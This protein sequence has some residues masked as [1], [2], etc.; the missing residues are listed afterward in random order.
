MRSIIK[1]IMKNSIPLLALLLVAACGDDKAGQ[2]EVQ[3]MQAMPLPVVEI[4]TKTVTTYSDYPTSIEG[5]INSEVRAKIPGYITEV[6]VDEGQ[7]VRRGQTLFRLETESL[8]Q[9][10]EA[11]KANVNAAQVE[12]D[13]LTPLVEKDII[14]SVQLETA[15]ARLQQSKS[16][17]N[18]VV[19]SIG[20][21]TITSPV[22]G[23]VGEIRLRMG[24]LISPNDQDPLTTVSDISAVYA[25]FSMNEKEYLDFIQNTAGTTKA[26]KINNLPEV[27]L[28]LANGSEYPQKGTIETINSQINKNTGAVSFRALFNNDNGILNNGNSGI[29]KVPKIYEDVV[30]V[31][32]EA[33]FENQNN[34]FVYTLEKDSANTIRAASKAITIK[35]QSG[36]LF[37]IE[38][39]LEKGETIIGKGVGKV[40][41]GMA[42]L[43]QKVAFDSIAQ[44]IRTE[45]Q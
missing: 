40:R 22:D 44:P 11:A 8:S 12:V 36:I 3:G 14:G 31:P 39:G 18:S 38:T 34:R 45:F 13:K 19:S 26:E 21:A 4:P 25:F 33:T 10:A 24:S 2:N 43:P 42:I 30:V 1:S 23:Y 15:K 6:L 5:V 29:V 35:G 16:S 32:Q 27:T 41:D 17:Y 37:L 7:K 9:D 20:Y 28:I